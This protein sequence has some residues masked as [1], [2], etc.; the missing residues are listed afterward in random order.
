MNKAEG[1]K[2]SIV[3]DGPYRVTGEVPVDCESMECDGEGGAVAWHKER[4]YVAKGPSALLCRCGH[5]RRRP[6]CDGTHSAVG[7]RGSE[8]ANRPSYRQTARVEPGQAVNLLDDKSLCVG[9]RF[10]DVGK[11]A[12]RYAQE[13]GDPENLTRAVEECCN[14]PSGRL[15]ITDF[16]GNAIEPA[17]APSISAIQDPVYNCRGPL[18]VKGGIE[19]EGAN[20][21]SYEVRNRVTLCRCGESKNQPY[22]DGA[23]Y[24]CSHMHGLDG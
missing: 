15:T 8:T 4:E 10:C 9:A 24:A 7:F 2:I 13:S 12:W 23:H 18:W 1:R 16:D 3:R 5:T 20:G 17:L 14:C 19:I 21:E 11:T 22:C 6:F